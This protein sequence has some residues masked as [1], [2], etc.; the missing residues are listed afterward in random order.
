MALT[1][2]LG[3]QVPI[4]VRIGY[5]KA[6]TAKMVVMSLSNGLITVTCNG[7]SYPVAPTATD[8][9]APG[10]SPAGYVSVVT[11]TG[12]AEFTEYAYT[13]S[14]VGNAG[15][16]SGSFRTLPSE[17]DDFCFYFVT[18]DANA[19][20]AEV[21]H[22]G[23]GFYKNIRQQIT[24]PGA[25]PCVGILHVDDHG[26]NSNRKF[27]TGKPDGL[28]SY[29]PMTFNT[30]YAYCAAWLNHYGLHASPSGSSGYGEADTTIN[31]YANNDVGRSPDRVWC[32]QNLPVWPQWGDWE[33]WNDIGM[34]FPTTNP[35]VPNGYHK[36]YT[37]NVGNK[38]GGGYLAWQQLM[39][40][41]QPPSIASA[42][43]DAN[44]WAFDL[45]CIRVIATDGI[46]NCAGN[47][48]TYEANIAA[49]DT[50][51]PQITSM[52]GAG[53]I[54]DIRA[55]SLHHLPFTMLGM[56]NGVRYMASSVSEW[57]SGAQHPI[58]NHCPAEFAALF[59][60][61]GS[62]SDK[63]ATLFTM[64]GD[65]HNG[66]VYKHDITDGDIPTDFYEIGAGT[67][68][69]ST[70]F[71][72][73]T[74]LAETPMGSAFR[75]STVEHIT[76]GVGA[77]YGV[78]TYWGVKVSVFGSKQTREILIEL[79]GADS[80]VMWSGRFIGWKGTQKF[81]PDFPVYNIV[82]TQHP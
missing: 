60:S 64:N 15:Q 11:L 12:L 39:A 75:G 2:E 16:V 82:G 50:A 7:V 19:L 65:Y 10:F 46:T 37:G 17:N 79:M 3:P 26:Y 56:M 42:D 69:R 55:V 70:N 5:A 53:Q 18:C 29:N 9:D 67:M 66:H 14:Q 20:L 45:G 74:V 81:A 44:H 21:V 78:G 71:M 28:E 73:D 31:A 48:T 23:H 76:E 72:A 1:I 6:P 58:K 8:S 52:L 33:F 43:T 62:L 4:G 24:A 59:T 77:G 25:L 47:I 57:Q 27:V 34:D 13:V 38:D 40:P 63:P 61:A 49:S 32:M 22:T 41:L 80:S 35:G 51:V 68:S 30:A 36:T 54:A